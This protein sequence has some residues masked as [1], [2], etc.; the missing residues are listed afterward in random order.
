MFN[1]GRRPTHSNAH[2][3]VGLIVFQ[4]TNI[5]SKMQVKNWLFGYGRLGSHSR[6][7]NY[8]LINLKLNKNTMHKDQKRTSFLWI[9]EGN[10]HLLAPKESSEWFL[11]CIKIEHSLQKKGANQSLNCNKTY[12]KWIHHFLLSIWAPSMSF[13]QAKVEE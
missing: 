10:V 3:W 8:S 1:Y 4:R 6:A 7:W 13:L 2:A 11:L 5:L 12:I 9:L